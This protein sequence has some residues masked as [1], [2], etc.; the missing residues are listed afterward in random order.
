MIYPICFFE[1]W[2]FLL[3]IVCSETCF[4]YGLCESLVS[5]ILYGEVAVSWSIA[6]I[7]NLD[8]DIQSHL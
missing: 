4:I 5:V 3:C 1:E 6:R 7:V 2:C 8:V